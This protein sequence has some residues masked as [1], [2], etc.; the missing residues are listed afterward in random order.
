MNR[1][2]RKLMEAEHRLV[3]D[4][5]I[6]VIIILVVLLDVSSHHE[7]DLLESQLVGI[8]HL[9]LQRRLSSCLQTERLIDFNLDSEEAE[10]CSESE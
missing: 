3:L 2:L 7:F 4:G 6:G 1:H 5:R 10:G 9:A 8:A